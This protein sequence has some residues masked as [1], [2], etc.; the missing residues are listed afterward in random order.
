MKPSR[1]DIRYLPS[2]FDANDPLLYA[3]PRSASFRWK[4]LEEFL[5]TTRA[6]GLLVR[7]PI[8]WQALFAAHEACQAAGI[9]YLANDPDNAPVGAAALRMAGV[10][11]VLTEASR[12][13]EFWSYCQERK[14]VLPSAW[15]LVHDA[16]S[17]THWIAPES[18]SQT[19]SCVFQEVHIMPGSPILE[20]CANLAA[21]KSTHFHIADAY[22]L[23]SESG[24]T[25][26]TSISND[27]PPLSDIVC[28]WNL[29]EECLCACGRATFRRI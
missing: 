24:R 7:T 17:T 18:I 14:T 12:A 22:T 23:R 9:P 25:H 19:S 2:S 16:R 6:R 29:A 20:Q 28:N 11:S 21:Q 27:A 3:V 8:Y 10:D 13:H 4:S 26:I 1:A 15:F 5:G